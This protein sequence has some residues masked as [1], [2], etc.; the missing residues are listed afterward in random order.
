MWGTDVPFCVANRNSKKACRICIGLAG[1]P[2]SP[3]SEFL[4]RLCNPLCKITIR[5]Q[6]YRNIPQVT[7]ALGLS[8]YSE[9]GLYDML[10]Y[11]REQPS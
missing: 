6:S 9:A 2:A 1:I 10:E 3:P 5:G 11:Q 7:S 8:G 4:I